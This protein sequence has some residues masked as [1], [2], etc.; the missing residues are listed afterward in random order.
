MQIR[1]VYYAK[2]QGS[3]TDP[4]PTPATGQAVP[5]LGATAARSGD[6]SGC[7][8]VRGQAVQAREPLGG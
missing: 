1:V 8:G 4:T 6:E 3:E 7:G 2:I 5:W